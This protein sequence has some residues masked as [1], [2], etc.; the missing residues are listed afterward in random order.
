[1][2][3]NRRSV[4]GG[5][6]GALAS[7]GYASAQQNPCTYTGF[8]NS[9][10]YGPNF[11]PI[12]N[13]PRI[14]GLPN[15]PYSNYPEDG[16][17]DT[18]RGLHE[19]AREKGLSFGAA[20]E[21]GLY[22]ANPTRSGISYRN[23]LLRECGHFNE[24]SLPA[25]EQVWAS[26]IAPGA[27]SAYALM[28]AFVNFATTNGKA[29]RLLP[30]IWY[31]GMPGWAD[32]YFAPNN[33]GRPSAPVNISNLSKRRAETLMRSWITSM[34][35]RYAGRIEAWDVVN[36][37]ETGVRLNGPWHRTLGPAYIEQAFH[38]AREADP[39]ARLMLNEED[40]DHSVEGDGWFDSQRTSLLRRLERLKARNVPVD[41]VGLQAHLGSLYT[42]DQEVVRNFL[43][44]IAQMGYSIEITELDIND[45]NFAATPQATRDINVRAIGKAYLDAVLD[46][47]NVL[48]VTVWGLTDSDPPTPGATNVW[49]ANG[50]LNQQA[51]RRRCDVDTSIARPGGWTAFAPMQHRSAPFDNT[52]QRKEF[53]K[54]I[55]QAFKWAPPQNKAH[56]DRLR[57]RVI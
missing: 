41:G 48:G 50:W 43:R 24:T 7:A 34:M 10:A 16:A 39:R 23:L 3:I 35:G 31:Q 28:D 47:P 2:P 9:V 8:P 14:V 20:V 19:W 46:E 36:E 6:I 30:L 11:P 12:T 37:A 18:S 15:P 52:F 57:G 45:R 25:M 17:W 56:R 1:M 29:V 49:N 13:T 26:G 32:A 21:R 40:T 54:G 22:D 44:E 4:L 55:W 53:W 33:P 51:D 5:V 38:M 42:L 27:E